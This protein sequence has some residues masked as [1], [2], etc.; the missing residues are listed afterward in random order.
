[1]KLIIGGEKDMPYRIS[2]CCK[3]KLTD[4]IV[5]YITKTKGV[6]IHKITCSFVSGA[7]PERL[8]KAYLSTAEQE[9]N[10][11]KYQVS[12]LLEVEDRQGYLKEIID[13]FNQRKVTILNFAALKKDGKNLK[14]RI[15]IDI[16]DEEQLDQIIS[17]L[18]MIDGVTGVS[19]M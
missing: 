17:N 2:S 8:L 5:G 9:E 10:A 15:I 6:S 18:E 11:V 19:R 1:M 13:F 12:L 16:A 3:P 14:R 4:Q 7:A